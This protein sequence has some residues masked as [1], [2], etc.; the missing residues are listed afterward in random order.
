MADQPTYEDLFQEL[1]V[2]RENCNEGAEYIAAQLTATDF[3]PRVV[4]AALDSFSDLVALVVDMLAGLPTG[5]SLTP[6][7]YALKA[8]RDAY[9]HAYHKALEYKD[10]A[11]RQYIFEEI[12]VPLFEDAAEFGHTGQDYCTPAALLQ[13]LIIE[14]Q[15]KQE[16]ESILVFL[17]DS[18]KVFLNQ[19][20]RGIEYLAK[21]VQDTVQAV[22]VGVGI[23]PF[24]VVGAIGVALLRRLK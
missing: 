11:R 1:L 8:R 6:D 16:S 9:Y 24:V 17:W 22:V 4:K 5:S 13:L 2:I 19:L 20:K 3:A 21:V 15:A 18:T 7:V 23:L 12:W 14:E 10:E